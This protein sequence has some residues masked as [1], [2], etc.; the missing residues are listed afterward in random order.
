[1]P[2]QVNCQACKKNLYQG[3]DLK[4]PEEILQMYDGK[5]PNCG[6]KLSLTPQNVKVTPSSKRKFRNLNI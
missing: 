2:Q 6:N 5:C 4:S 3:D 1:L